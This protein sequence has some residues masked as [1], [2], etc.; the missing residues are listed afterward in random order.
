MPELPEVEVLVRHLNTVLPGK[1]VLRVD[2]LRAKS[3]R[4]TRPEELGHALSGASFQRVQRRGKYLL[5]RCQR[6]KQGSRQE[7]T[8]LGH[9][10][11]TGRMYVVSQTEPLPRHAAVVLNLGTERFVFEDTR[12]FG[13]F[14]LDT[15][16]AE[17]LGPEPLSP[18]FV[19]GS[20]ALCL[21]A[22]KRPIKTRLLTQD[23]VAGIGNIYASEALFQAR[24]SPRRTCR[25]L[26]PLEARRL[27]R[28]IRA[29]LRR[30]ITAGS[31]IPLNFG[32]E[33]TRDGLFYYGRGP[34]APVSH[35]ER[36]RVY[37]RAGEPCVRCKTLVRRIVQA[38]RSTFYCPACQR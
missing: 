21:R 2:V 25:S 8:V 36:L 31:T 28:S 37:D 16:A 15:R 9:L 17:L 14:S 35:T 26:R 5:F 20:F 27:W 29:V 3:V 19:P 18:E 32:G 13:R 30:A 23:I 6:T 38:G 1:K 12:Y 7:I 34:G 22:S 10:G 11:M 4:P 33:G 24:I